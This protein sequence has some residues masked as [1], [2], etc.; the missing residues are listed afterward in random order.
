MVQQRVLSKVHDARWE[1]RDRYRWLL[2]TGLF[3]LTSTV[4][5]FVVAT[6][7]RVSMASEILIAIAALALV[8]YN[9]AIKRYWV[10]G[11]AL[12]VTL[13]AVMGWIVSR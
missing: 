13:I 3:V 4:F 10:V 11:I 12:L 9:A 1:A 5:S 2:L 8:A 6:P 7:P